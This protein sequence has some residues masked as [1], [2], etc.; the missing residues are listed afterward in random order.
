MSATVPDV[1]ESVSAA[2]VAAAEPGFVRRLLR[3]PL[4]VASLAFLGV[5]ILAAVF[6]PLL[7]PYGPTEADLGHVLAPPSW[8]HPFG[9]D[10]LGRD[11]LSR[12]MYGGRVTL[13]GAATG[14]LVAC[15][16]GLTAG[17]LAGYAGGWWDRAVSRATDMVLAIPHIIILLAVLTVFG[18][19]ETI[20]MVTFG[21]LISPVLIRVVRASTL[22]VRHELFVDAAR[23]SGLKRWQIVSRHILPR[24]GGAVIVV[25]SLI[26]AAAILTET[27]L[28]YLGLGVPPPE[29]SWGELVATAARQIHTQAWLL[30]PSGLVVSLAVL[31]F[32]LLGDATRDASTE[33]WQASTQRRRRAHG[34]RRRSGGNR[35]IAVPDAA[36][37]VRDLA[38]DFDSTAGPI[39]VV[40]GVSFAIGE[41]ETVGIVG[42]SG[43]GKTMMARSLI[44]LLP[45]GGYSAGG[46]AWFCG[47]DL[48]GLDEPALRRVR[49]AEIGVVF[50]NAIACLDPVFTVGSQLGE[51]VSTHEPKASRAAVRARVVE[52][53]HMVNLPEPEVIARRYPHE[54]SG[55][56]AQR[57]A[58]AGALVGRP[59]LL[60]ADEPTTAL[61][62]TLQ[63]EILDLLRQL[64]EQTGMA[65]L[66]ITHDWGVVADLCQRAIVMYAGQVVEAGEVDELFNRPLHPY[67]Q[68]LLRSNPLPGQERQLLAGIPGTVPPPSLWPQACRFQPRCRYATADCGLGAIPLLQLETGRHARCIHSERLEPEA[69][70]R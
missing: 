51:L 34:K 17:L 50:Q 10:D 48:L 3:R 37:S 67:T 62:V 55:G 1:I 56:M 2:E 38:V 12:V 13:V 5:A 27:G 59:R 68:G 23:V 33:S 24:V 21:V 11:V 19:D 60:I 35:T 45:G 6:A 30:L 42:E 44:G 9:T 16:I 70:A 69:L 22:A 8:A 25:V 43:C 40:D 31:A 18:R 7:A 57:V 41:G 61:D 20:A 47:R 14:V 46:E 32:G 54:L 28:G 52:L 49:G 58:I 29:P 63:A 36:L 66:M 26:C 53:L 64:Q 39:R 4:A 65:I 15:A